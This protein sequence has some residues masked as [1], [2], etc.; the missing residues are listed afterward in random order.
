MIKPSQT[1]ERT[2]YL[3]NYLI[4]HKC[5]DLLEQSEV[6]TGITDFL[7]REASRYFSLYLDCVCNSPSIDE[8][9]NI[10]KPEFGENIQ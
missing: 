2:S 7:N 1:P 4:L 8:L 5:A 6:D 9:Y 3:N 10:L